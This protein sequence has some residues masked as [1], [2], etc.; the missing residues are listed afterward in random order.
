M[1]YDGANIENYQ[2]MQIVAIF[3]RGCGKY[4]RNNYYVYICI[5]GGKGHTK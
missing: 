1:V 2:R 3:L 5:R 4:L